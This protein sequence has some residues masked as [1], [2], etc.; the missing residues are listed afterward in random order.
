MIKPGSDIDN[1]LLIIKEI[2]KK[3]KYKEERGKKDQ[4]FK[5]K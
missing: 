5:T 4:K 2:K 1:S 3:R